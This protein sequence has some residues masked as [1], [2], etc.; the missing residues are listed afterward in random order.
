MLAAA[1]PSAIRPARAGWKRLRSSSGTLTLRG[2]ASSSEAGRQAGRQ[3]G[4][5]GTPL[6]LTGDGMNRSATG[7]LLKYCTLTVGIVV[8]LALSPLF[9]IVLE[10]SFRVNWTR[11]S[12]IGQSY[13]GVSALLSAAA[14]VGVAFSIRLQTRQTAH[15]ASPG[16]SPGTIRPVPHGYGQSGIRFGY[17]RG[18]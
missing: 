18:T 7:R 12:E 15:Y 9:L 10:A 1:L 16:D 6:S 2:E 8:A 4:M 5:T 14:L 13:T 3:A 17:R 11:L